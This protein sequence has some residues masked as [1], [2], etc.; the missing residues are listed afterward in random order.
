MTANLEQD[1]ASDAGFALR[2]AF[3]RRWIRILV[4]GSSFTVAVVLAMQILPWRQTAALLPR[5]SPFLALCSAIAARSAS[6]AFVLTALPVFL[7][8]LARGRWFCATLCPTWVLANTASRLR[9]GARSRFSSWPRFG[10][11]LA[12]IGLG[13]AVGGYPLFLW[14]DPL[15][16]FNGFFSTLPRPATLAALAPASGLILVLLLSLYRPHVWCM[17][18]CP[19]GATQDFLGQMGRCVKNRMFPRSARDPADPPPPCPAPVVGRRFFLLAIGG[20]L[21]A[22]AVRRFRSVSPSPCIRPPGAVNENLFVGL[23]TRCGNC[24]RACRY[25]ILH[26]DFGSSGL[27]GLG[28]PAI[29]ITPGYCNEWCNDCTQVCPVGAIQPLTLEAKR[30]VAIGTAV[31][32]KSRCIAWR[33]GQSCMVCQE[34]CPYNAIRAVESGGANCPVVD[35]EMC[36]G[37]GACESQCP[38]FPDKAITVRGIQQRAAKPLAV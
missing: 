24:L 15:S 21:A 30:N 2:H 17:R 12:V 26:F 6:R 28:T 38:A 37:C 4:R 33:D 14:L 23:C 29:Q 25:R 9:P 10:Q 19:L 31:V 35:D 1:G 22:F 7:L 34:F 13:G 32:E 18:L 11:V 5:L 20:F 27:A 8:A 3:R 16:L 36:R